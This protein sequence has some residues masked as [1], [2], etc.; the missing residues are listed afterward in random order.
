MKDQNSS[1]FG[2]IDINLAHQMFSQGKTQGQIARHFGV[3][4]AAV[5]KMFKKMR[6]YIP[7]VVAFEKA[8]ELVEEKIDAMGQLR[9]IN[10]LIHSREEEVTL[11]Q[12]RF[13][14]A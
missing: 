8:A 6:G 3:S 9:R 12:N 2:K 4:D 1:N 7:R 5:S 11:V 13:L 14:D 10:G